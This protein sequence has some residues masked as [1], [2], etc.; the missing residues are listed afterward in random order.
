M[1][2]VS[3]SSPVAHG[4]LQIRNGRPFEAPGELRHDVSHDRAKLIDLAPEVR[5]LHGERVHDLEPLVGFGRVL[6]Q[7]VVVHERA[8]AAG[9]DQRREPIC[10]LI[11]LMRLVHQPE[12]FVNQV[13]ENAR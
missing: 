4:T 3:G 8:D 5:L 11:E 9:H 7:V 2:R 10:D 6:Q 13:A 1:A 12:A